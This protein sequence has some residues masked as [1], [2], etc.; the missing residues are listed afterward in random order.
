MKRAVEPDRRRYPRF[1]HVLD[2]QAQE[3]PPV[4]YSGA[5][6]P[7]IL[8]RV[9]N[10]SKG[11][12]CLLSQRM[13]PLSSLLRCEIA[14]AEVPVAIPTLFRVRWTKKQKVEVDSYLSGVQFLF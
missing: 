6:K 8:G 4:D 11:G 14:I 9:Q 12:L 3:C 10:V 7:P 1:P 2:V 5:V 13:I